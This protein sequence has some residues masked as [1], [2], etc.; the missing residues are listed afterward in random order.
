MNSSIK[1]VKMQRITYK[2]TSVPSSFVFGDMK[3][4]TEKE[5]KL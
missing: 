2:I 3:L 5:I 4:L 1:G